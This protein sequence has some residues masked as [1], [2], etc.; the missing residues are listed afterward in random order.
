MQNLSLTKTDIF[1]YK[2]LTFSSLSFVTMPS[3]LACG[4]EKIQVEIG[5]NPELFHAKNA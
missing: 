1:S 5:V 3:F 4:S 2:L